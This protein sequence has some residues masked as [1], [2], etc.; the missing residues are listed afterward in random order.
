LTQFGRRL[1]IGSVGVKVRAMRLPLRLATLALSLLTGLSLVGLPLA[2]GGTTA[3]PSR[4]GDSTS[5]TASDY[6]RDAAASCPAAQPTPGTHCNGEEACTY[7]EGC[8]GKN[9]HFSCYYGSWISHDPLSACADECP[10]A[11]PIPGT[12]CTGPSS[13]S[14]TFTDRCSKKDV[15]FSCY[16]GS[17][18]SHD[19]L[20][21]CDHEKCDPNRC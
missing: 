2:C 14:C 13:G 9:V 21:W 1:D 17:W 11:E 6:S 19:A 7:V 16:Y 20:S 3:E 4:G 18:I 15:H 10:A 8:S 12:P 5:E